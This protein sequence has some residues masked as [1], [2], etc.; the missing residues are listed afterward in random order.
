M[1]NMWIKKIDTFQAGD[2]MLFAPSFLQKQWQGRTPMQNWHTANTQFYLKP[3]EHIGPHWI[4]YEL[5][6]LAQ[7]KNHNGTG[8]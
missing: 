2:F 6:P 5:Q 3:Q 8:A 1:E 7:Q 4:L